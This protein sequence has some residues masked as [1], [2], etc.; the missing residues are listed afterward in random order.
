[1]MRI[2]MLTNNYRPFVGGVPISVERQAVE[3]AKQGNHVTVFAPQYEDGAENGPED[4]YKGECSGE[5]DLVRF[6]TN[7]QR[8]ENGAVIPKLVPKELF[9]VF[10]RELFDL[11]HVHHPVFVGPVA[12]YFGKKY[13]IPVVYTYHTRYEDYLHY[14]RFFREKDG[15]HIVRNKVTRKVLRFARETVV[16]GYM[17]WFT[18]Q[19]DLVLAPSAGMQKRIREKGTTTMTAVFPTGLEAA[20]YQEEAEAAR[21]IR[22]EFMPGK[23]GYLFCST[24]RLEE[25]KNP[26]FLL[27][28]IWLLKQ[29]MDRKFRVLLIGEG[30]IRQ[31]LEQKVR[32]LQLQD[33]VCF[34]GSVPNTHLNRY[35]QACDVFLFASKSETQGIVLAESMAAGCPV[36]AVQASGVED[37]VKNGVNGFATEEDTEAWV[38]KVLE[39]TKEEVLKPMRL[40]AKITAERYRADRLALYEEMLYRQCITEKYETAEVLDYAYGETGKKH[41]TE[42]VLG[43]FKAS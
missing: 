15:R 40:Q 35:L 30:S 39:I 38:E 31:R 25:E 2:A 26:D 13:N 33:V 24:G 37:I 23:D 8:M 21:Q 20:F 43:V 9:P 10:E 28:G 7:G 34:L 12:L 16:P 18:N 4:F 3:L 32:E 27:E 29:R 11:I 6:S 5:I 14:L 41:F 1:M 19:C 22:Q 42:A 17:R 36:V